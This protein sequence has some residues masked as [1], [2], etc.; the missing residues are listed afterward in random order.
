MIE[1]AQ[2]QDFV[3]RPFF[4]RADSRQR[5]QF[6]IGSRPGEKQGVK[7]GFPAEIAVFIIGYYF[8]IIALR[9]IYTRDIRLDIA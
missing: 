7:P 4:P 5:K 1:L 2:G 3:F 8:G 6:L 9:R